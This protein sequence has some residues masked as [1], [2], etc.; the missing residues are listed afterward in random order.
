MDPLRSIHN[1]R[2]A[3]LSDADVNAQFLAAEAKREQLMAA[4][5][6]G[7]DSMESA[8][9]DID[10]LIFQLDDELCARNLPLSRA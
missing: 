6:A 4:Y 7:D 5:D 2:F 1:P 8:I 9:D 3:D 10:S